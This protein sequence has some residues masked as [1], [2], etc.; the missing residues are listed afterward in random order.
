MQPGDA[1]VAKGADVLGAHAR[2]THALEFFAGASGAL[3]LR[4]G[5]RAAGDRKRGRAGKE[6][7]QHGHLQR[8]T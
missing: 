7:L 1:R 5:I 4:I 3:L 8:Q 2:V 6:R